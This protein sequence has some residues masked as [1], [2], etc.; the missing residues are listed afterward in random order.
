MDLK[1]KQWI[2]NQWLMKKSA[3][4]L[5]FTIYLLQNDF[6]TFI[7]II[8]EFLN[9]SISRLKQ[10]VPSWYCTH[11]FT[12]NNATCDLIFIA[13]LK[14]MLWGI[15]IHIVKA[16]I[17][18]RTTFSSMVT[19]FRFYFSRLFFFHHMCVLNKKRFRPMPSY[20]KIKLGKWLWIEFT[21]L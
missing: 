4:S 18:P 5:I 12:K 1:H 14:V 10:T 8:N 7:W 21:W 20:N 17:F 13:L 9:F 19:S 6:D 11:K 16:L 2:K 15:R 3:F